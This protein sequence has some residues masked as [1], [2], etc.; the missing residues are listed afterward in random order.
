MGVGN[1]KGPRLL[2]LI[3]TTAGT[4]SE[5]LFVS[6]I[7]VVVT[8]KGGFP[9]LLSFQ[10]TVLDPV[11]TLGLPAAT[12]AATGIDAMVHAIEAYASKNKNNNPMSA[13]LQRR[14]WC[15]WGAQLKWLSRIQ[16]LRS[17]RKMLLGSMLVAEWLLQILLW[18]QFTLWLIHLGGVFI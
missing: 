5:L 16:K 9:R 15:S 2:S 7:T 14:H 11:L 12:T 3:P 8:K 1:A 18:P 13:F 17:E 6:I 10:T 4:G